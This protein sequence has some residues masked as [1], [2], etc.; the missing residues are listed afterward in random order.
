MAYESPKSGAKPEGEST[1]K[2]DQADVLADARKRFKQ[3]I[4]ANVTNRKIQVEDIRFAAASPDNQ[5]QWPADVLK[6]RIGGEG[7]P[8]RPTIT[9]NKLPQHIKLVTNEQRQNRPSIKVLPVDDKADVKVAEVLNGV[10]RHIEANSDADIAYDTAA[11][12]QVTIGEGY[13]RI[14]TDYCNEMSVDEQDIYI[15]P[16]K[17]SFSVY[18]DPDGL[19]KDSTGRFCDW[20]FIT[21]KIHKDSFKKQF[22]NATQTNWDDLGKGD[23][24]ACWMEEDHVVIAEYFCFKDVKTKIVKWSDGSVTKDDELPKAPMESIASRQTTIRK[25]MWSKMTGLEVLEEKEW[26]GKYIPLVRV[27]GNEWEIDGKSIVSGIVRNA[28]DA[29]RMF[30]YWVSQEAELLALAPKAPFMA[31]IEAIE[32]FE[33]YYDTANYTNR[34]YL[35]FNAFNDEG[36]PIPAPQRVIP[37]VPS[38]GIMQAKLGAADDLQAT[39]G[40][41]NPSLGAEAKE[42]SGKAIQ[43]RQRQA[44]VGTFHY[45]DNLAR[46]IRQTGRIVIDLIPKIYDTKRVARILGEDGEPDHVTLDPNASQ[47]YAKVAGPDGAIEEIYNPTIGQYDVRV[48]VGPSYTTKRQ[49][50]AEFMSDVL[51]GNK[52]LMQV[53]GDLYFGMLDVPGADEISK[54]LK[55]AVPPNLADDDEEEGEVIQTPKGPLPVSQAAAA[56]ESLMQQIDG[57]GQQIQDTEKDRQAVE[58]GKAELDKREM[59]LKNTEDQIRAAEQTL[60]LKEQ[61]AIKTLEAE[62]AR[63]EADRTKIIADMKM[64]VNDAVARLEGMK[65]AAEMAKA[66]EDE[67]AVEAKNQQSE[68]KNQQVEGMQRMLIEQL[69]GAIAALSAPRRTTLR[70][71]GSGMPVE[72]VSEVVQ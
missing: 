41:Y 24:A 51:R 67:V 18:M 65:Q 31:P 29:Q 68:E 52:E 2:K 1:S 16:I 11:E 43:A 13:W 12:S 59:A 39:M 5:W 14:L 22:P 10:I 9:I 45:I 40:Q 57:L 7:Q 48:T 26:A 15:A 25:V 42:K 70:S 56:I 72:A 8:P 17:N 62:D 28:K 35:P 6:S 49:E 32:G 21:D 4:D 3:A 69:S 54:R 60:Q 55:K 63:T 23:D 46:S 30:N 27:V 34:P 44:D 50:A 66:G 58:A 36:K 61:L 20:G 37:P 71:D 53:I 19:R 64:M 38:Q 47:A 33:K